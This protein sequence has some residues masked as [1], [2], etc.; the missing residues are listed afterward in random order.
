ML[1]SKCLVIKKS[2][3]ILYQ[4]NKDARG[5]TLLEATTHLRA[6]RSSPGLDIPTLCLYVAAP[7]SEA[8]GCRRNTRFC[9]QSE[10]VLL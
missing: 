6:K 4:S 9:E 10:A 7:F 1:Y 8:R 2:L 5:F 3:I